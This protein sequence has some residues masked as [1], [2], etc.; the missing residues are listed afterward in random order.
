MDV[1]SVFHNLSTIETPRLILRQLCLEDVADVFAYTSD[2]DVA[3]HTSWYPHRTIENSRQFVEWVIKRYD[4]GQPAPWGVQHK[5]DTK[6]IGTCGFGAWIV[7]HS[8]AEIGYAIAKPYW[9]QGLVTEAVRKVLSYGFTSMN[10][11]R[12]E[13]TCVP[14]NVGSWR[15]M[16]K[17]GMRREGILR[18]W[19]FSKDQFMDIAMY[20]ILRSEWEAIK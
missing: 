11:N 15:V 10:L 16:E 12:I 14:E 4:A 6:I 9:N 1:E 7:E 3:R 20:S 19:V 2:P 8:R 17:V 13:A 18:Q 5:V